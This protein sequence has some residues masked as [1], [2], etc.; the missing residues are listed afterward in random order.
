MLIVSGHEVSRGRERQYDERGDRHSDTAVEPRHVL[1]IGDQ[2]PNSPRPEPMIDENAPDAKLIACRFGAGA[3][4][5][6][7]DY[8]L[9]PI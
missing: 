5:K 9:Q 8:R 6:G 1:S 3:F 2:P 4:P 7:V